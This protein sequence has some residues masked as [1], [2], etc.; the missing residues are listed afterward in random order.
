MQRLS[1]VASR[2]NRQYLDK[3]DQMELVSLSTL[4]KEVCC[5]YNLSIRPLLYPVKGSVW[6]LRVIFTV[7]CLNHGLGL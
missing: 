7:S 6:N 4:L 5:F 3:C 1:L 2:E